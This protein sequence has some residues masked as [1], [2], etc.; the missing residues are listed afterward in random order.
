[1][2]GNHALM[3]QQQGGS[4]YINQLLS[5]NSFRRSQSAP[6]QT[7]HVAHNHSKPDRHHDMQSKS[8]VNAKASR[9]HTCIADR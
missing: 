7:N 8:H 9:L 4:P 6:T 3:E 5:V 2:R 1:M